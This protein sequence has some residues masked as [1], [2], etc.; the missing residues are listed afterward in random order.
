MA[1]DRSWRVTQLDRRSRFTS[2]D[3]IFI[4]A[5]SE[6]QRPHSDEGEKSASR[7]IRRGGF[8]S[9]SRAP[10]SHSAARATPASGRA[11]TLAPWASRAGAIRDIPR[12]RLLD[13]SLSPPPPAT[14]P[15]PRPRAPRIRRASVGVPTSR[16][17]PRVSFSRAPPRVRPSLPPSTQN[18]L[19]EHGRAP[20]LRA[21]HHALLRLAPLRV[22]RPALV[23]HR[24]DVPLVS[25]PRPPRPRRAP[26]ARD[27]REP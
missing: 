11:S 22:V 14:S 19:R 13:S 9:R 10:T 15:L 2:N 18:M 23:R 21:R 5:N 12:E 6:R 24:V 16:G 26:R 25:R 7:M 4:W 20:L 1:A 27:P 3:L 17:C 8:R